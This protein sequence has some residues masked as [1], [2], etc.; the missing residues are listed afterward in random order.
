MRHVASLRWARGV[1]LGRGMSR[2]SGCGGSRG[3]SQPS[4]VGHVQ[5]PPGC[6]LRPGTAPSRL[7]QSLAAAS[8]SSIASRSCLD[9][10]FSPREPSLCLGGR[11]IGANWQRDCEC[12]QHSRPLLRWEH[13]LLAPRQDHPSPPS[14]GRVS[15]PG[16]C[17]TPAGVRA[18]GTLGQRGVASW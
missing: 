1:E 2:S 9:V 15:S 6:H 3:G 10:P 4:A 5:P 18:M 8:W 17:S 7:C 11:R 14:W 13:P 16:D 12:R